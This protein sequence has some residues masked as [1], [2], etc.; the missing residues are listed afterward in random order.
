MSPM[1]NKIGASRVLIEYSAWILCW[2][3]NMTSYSAY[4]RIKCHFLS[5]SSWW[6]KFRSNFATPEKTAHFDVCSACSC[7]RALNQLLSVNVQHRHI[8]IILVLLIF[9]MDQFLAATTKIIIIIVQIEMHANGKC[10]IAHQRSSCRTVLHMQGAW[11]MVIR[12]SISAGVSH[13]ATYG[14]KNRPNMCMYNEPLIPHTNIWIYMTTSA[15][16]AR[17]HGSSA[18]PLHVRIHNRLGI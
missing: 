9:D 8:I 14:Y 6:W 2:T 11:C 1:T 12:N 10:I 13:F 18:T 4:P 17:L 5:C 3:A 7:R 15:F 16:C